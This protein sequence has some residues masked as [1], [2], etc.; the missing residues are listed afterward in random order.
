MNNE[1]ERYEHTLGGRY[2]SSLGMY[3]VRMA[4]NLTT[5]LRRGEFGGHH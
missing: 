2:K 1:K 5:A 4:S 3:C